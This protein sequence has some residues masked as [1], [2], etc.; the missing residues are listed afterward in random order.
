MKINCD[1]CRYSEPIFDNDLVQCRRSA[2]V[3]L[4]DVRVVDLAIDPEMCFAW[5]VLRPDAW[6]GQHDIR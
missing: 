5:P 1:N 2:P 3:L 6:C 4:R